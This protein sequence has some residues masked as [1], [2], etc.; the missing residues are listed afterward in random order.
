MQDLAR[1]TRGC[2]LLFV[3]LYSSFSH[4]GEIEPIDDL[5][6]GVWT[7]FA[8]RWEKT[9]PVCIW[10]NQADTV[11]RVIVNGIQSGNKFLL[12][13]EVGDT[14]PYKVFWETGK[15]FKH[16]EQLYPNQRSKRSYSYDQNE[17]C[18]GMSSSQL[19]VRIVKK[20]LNSAPAA[21]YQDTILLMLSP[22]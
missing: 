12:S 18:G 11:Y 2:V 16:R 17:K 4:A 13:N 19:R 3:W 10:D 21:I 6:V 15:K 9:V 22:L 1:R 7:P 8:A 14:I 20:K 5:F